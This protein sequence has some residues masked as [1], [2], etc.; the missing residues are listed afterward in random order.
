MS[1]QM[2]YMGYEWVSVED[3]VVT[4][5]LTED[6]VSDFTDE[7]VLNLP[8][9]DDV[10]SAGKICGDIESDNG[11]LNLYSPVSGTI[12]E[13]NDAILENPSLLQEDPTDEGWLFKVEADD[14]DKLDLLSVR[15]ASTDDDDDDD[16]EDD[17]DSDDDSDDEDNE[18]E[19]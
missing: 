15:A 6:T 18:D 14:I 13:V 11:N 16:D 7:V 4:I 8:E 10:V 12:I 19:E 17:D 9:Q 1:E 2:T 5:G 3:G